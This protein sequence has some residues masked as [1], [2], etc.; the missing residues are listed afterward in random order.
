MERR[1]SACGALIPEGV[2]VDDGADRGLIFAFV[3]A[4]IGRQFEFVQSEWVK[5]SIVYPF[6]LNKLELPSD[7]RSDK[8][9]YQS[10]IRAIVYQ[11]SFWN[12]RAACAVA[13]FHRTILR[14]PTYRP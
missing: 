13:P 6:G 5:Y 3:G 14:G 11:H 7:V 9:E 10:A 4:H 2:L 8:C 1:D 12:Q